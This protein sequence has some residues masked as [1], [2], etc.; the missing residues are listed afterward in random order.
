MIF[1]GF[2][3][4][5]TI[6]DIGI[7]VSYVFL[8][9]K[10]FRVCSGKYVRLVEE[11]ISAYF[12]GAQ[13]ITFDSGRTALCALLCA[14]GVKKGDEVLL[15]AFTCVVVVNAI[16]YT[17]AKPIFV[18]IGDD[19]NM[20][21][22]DM[23]KKYSSRTKA[24]IIQHT[25]GAAA[26]VKAI[27]SFA[28]KK[29]VYTIEDCAHVFGGRHNGRLL[30]TFADAAMFSFGSDKPLSCGRGGV[31]IT[32]KDDLSAKV[33]QY[34]E[35]LPSSTCVSVGKY[36]FQY[37]YFPLGKFCYRLYVGKILLFLSKTIG[38]TPLVISKKEKQ[39]EVDGY[40]QTTFPNALAHILLGQLANI[41]AV[42]LHRQAIATQY[43]KG[44]QSINT[45]TLS[46]VK[47]TEDVP[48]RYLLLTKKQSAVLAEGKKRGIVLGDWYTTVVAP[49]DVDLRHS[50][51][52]AGS[53]PRAEL[54]ATQVV[55]LP[56]HSGITE[57]E[58]RKILTCITD[59]I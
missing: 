49:K 39:G 23:Q 45:I 14:G 11:R 17:G 46:Q 28:K 50:E 16:K 42:N 9:W 12:L 5:T 21:V 15:Q 59:T 2:S 19:G 56:T 31:A 48:L 1:T 52:V 6:K 34:Q 22:A 25:F 32:K 24:I 10:W 55:N 8:P 27:M 35:S 58:V 57:K 20:D 41:D 29:G 40:T 47:H 51:Y 37:L 38:M 43:T 33:R 54:F 30:G 13:A 36:L 3:S 53:C 18:D 26:D 4:N 7:A 44:L